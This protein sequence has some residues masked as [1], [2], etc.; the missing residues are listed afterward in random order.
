MF[1]YSNLPVIP[2]NI[3]EEK[4]LIQIKY[5]HFSELPSVSLS[6]PIFLKDLIPDPEITP[7]VRPAVLAI[8]AGLSIQFSKPPG[9]NFNIGQISFNSYLNGICV[10]KC[11]ISNCQMSQLS[12]E[13]IFIVNIEP[14]AF[15]NPITGPI[16][17]FKSVLRG[18]L[19][20]TLN[21]LLYDEWGAESTLLGIRNIVVQDENGFEIQWLS[22]FLLKMDFEYDIDA[23]R[24]LGGK[25]LEKTGDISNAIHQLTVAIIQQADCNLM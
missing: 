8:D 13:A 18:A 4:K 3:T 14:T 9:I 23:V 16:G 1:S 7:F 19:R 17:A 25:A 12:K 20:G 2:S 6:S 11:T 15:R 22:K 5:D 24:T 10:A 21:G